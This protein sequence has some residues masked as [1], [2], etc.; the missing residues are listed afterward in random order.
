MAYRG[1][2]IG[3]EENA[4]QSSCTENNQAREV[5]WVPKAEQETMI[6]ERF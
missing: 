2:L 4:G 5:A 3:L 1:T 6:P